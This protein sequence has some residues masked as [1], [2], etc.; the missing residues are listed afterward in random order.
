MRELDPAPGAEQAIDRFSEAE[1]RL[2]TLTN[3]SEESTRSLLRR[4]D[5]ED[6]FAA[7]LSCD[8]VRTTK[9]HQRVYELAK[10]HADGE[11]WLVAAHAWDVSGAA[12]AGLRTAWVPSVEGRYL[13]IYPEPDVT[14][15]DLAAAAD[16]ILSA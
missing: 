4:L 2:L 13:S 14:A 8:D 6:R 11:L 10:N 3:G 12:R 9:P 5:R 16:R 7:V 15:S 1:W